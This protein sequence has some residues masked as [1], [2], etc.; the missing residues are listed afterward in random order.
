MNHII[1]EFLKA[2]SNQRKIIIEENLPELTIQDLYDFLLIILKNSEYQI[3]EFTIKILAQNTQKSFEIAEILLKYV[4]KEFIN[5]PKYYGAMILKEII[6]QTDTN[7]SV[8]LLVS[9]YD[10]E[11]YRDIHWA[12]AMALA[13]L[14]NNLEGS[15]K[16]AVIEL[17]KKEI[18]Q[19]T[20]IEASLGTYL[21]NYTN[22]KFF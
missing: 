5:T 11:D 12:I 8:P 10:L 15:A 14:L 6:S 3:K 19:K 2:D 7:K 1:Q 13:T 9:A 17:I 22:I 16:E 21:R 20:D 4:S 18:G